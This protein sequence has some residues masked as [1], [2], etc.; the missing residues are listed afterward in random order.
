MSKEQWGH[1]YWKGVKDAQE[2]KATEGDLFEDSCFWLAHMEISNQFKDYD[3]SLYPVEEFISRCWFSGLDKTY[4]KKIYIYVLEHQPL[5]GYITGSGRAEDPWEKDY[6]VLPCLG[7]EACF[8]IIRELE[9]RW[10]VN[11]I[12]EREIELLESAGFYAKE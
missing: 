4:A 10:D 5:G 2:G 7:Q 6:F 9:K 1:G 11:K 8:N 12:R 3:R